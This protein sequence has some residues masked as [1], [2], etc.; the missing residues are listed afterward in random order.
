MSTIAV[1]KIKSR[2]RRKK[3]I[4]K[5]VT[6]SAERPRLVI[7]RSLRQVYAQLVDDVA[8]KTLTGVSSLSPELREQVAKKKPCEVGK[9]VG[10]AC[11][12]KALERNIKKVVFDR[13]GFPY[14]GRVKAVAEG[15]RKAGLQF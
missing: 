5:T 3:H 11:A 10:E 8:G 1:R 14:H 6:G 12:R 9:L 2:I 7:F 4:R 15:A 13:N